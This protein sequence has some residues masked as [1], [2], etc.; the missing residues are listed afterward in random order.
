MIT[1]QYNTFGELL[2]T[3]QHRHHL[4]TQEVGDK[5]SLVRQDLEHLWEQSTLHPEALV[6]LILDQRGGVWDNLTLLAARK[7]GYLEQ[8]TCEVS[9]S[10]KFDAFQ[11]DYLLTLLHCLEP[12]VQQAVIWE[13]LYTIDDERPWDYELSEWVARHDDWADQ[14]FRTWMEMDL[15]AEEW[16][17]M[18]LEKYPEQ[19]A[20]LSALPNSPMSAFFARR[21][22]TLLLECA[23]QQLENTYIARNQPDDPFIWAVSVF[24]HS[25]YHPI[26]ERL[27]LMTLLGLSDHLPDHTAALTDLFEVFEKYEPPSIQLPSLLELEKMAAHPEQY[28]RQVIAQL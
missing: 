21:P 26:P 9:P 18:L 2:E 6:A 25:E 22:Y 17:E 3:L 27:L 13:H 24:E 11:A 1:V 28:A 4:S 14:V 15:G 10:D 19:V 12:S 5:L 20:S 23:I 7:A 8:E 16:G